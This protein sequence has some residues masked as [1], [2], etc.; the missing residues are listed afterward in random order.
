[1][2][3]YTFEKQGGFD[4][5]RM[6]A[7][8]GK[9]INRH[10]ILRT[11]AI[12]TP[13]FSNNI[14]HIVLRDSGDQVDWTFKSYPD[15]ASRDLAVEVY[16]RNAPGFVL[17]R[18]PTRAALFQGPESSV[19]AWQI[20][21][22]QYDGWSFP[23][24]LKDLQSAYES[25]NGTNTTEHSSPPL[26]AAF[27]RWVNQQD[28]VSSLEYWKSHLM[29]AS[30]L[31]WP[32]VSYKHASSIV[33]DELQTHTWSRG[34]DVARFCGAQRITLS[35]LV[36][37]A[38]AVVLGKQEGTED[39]LFGVVTS[40]RT[41]DLKG[42]EDIVGSCI[43]TV[44]C[45]IR[46]P[47]HTAIEQLLKSVHQQSMDS[48][49]FQFVGLSDIIQ[50]HQGGSDSRGLFNILLVIENLPGLK[51][52]DH[53]FVGRNLRGH[54]LEMNY[55]LT[56]IVFP[57]PDN[58]ELQFQIQWDS[59]CLSS[60][61]IQWFCSHLFTAL[62][63]I[64]ENPEQEVCQVRMLSS[65]EERFVR[66][67]GAGH[68]PD[69]LLSSYKFFHTLVDD[70]AAQ[71]PSS[72]ALECFSGAALSYGELVT[73]ANQAAHGLQLRGVRPEVLVP[74]IF[75]KFQSAV[76]TV[77]SL[78]A[79]MKSAGAFVPLDAS[80]PAE[81]IASCIRQTRSKFVLCH[82]QIPIIKKALGIPVVTLEDL[83][84]GHDIHTPVT[85]GLRESSLSYVMFTSG[86]T[87][88]PKGVMLEHSNMMAFISKYV[89][90]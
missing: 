69:P 30:P 80:W 58:S 60:T 23:L 51:D 3:H 46:I 31:S 66:T 37:T 81:R 42:I 33:T 1:M 70:I 40:G 41:G 4:P 65:A 68:P 5:L 47:S 2:A 63:V 54:Q 7:A 22:S 75:D 13:G 89:L 36:R 38:L 62:D 9:V 26:Y 32:K 57:S 82:S 84:R 64:M 44:P 59:R 78:L 15:Q 55:P 45:R 76:D 10:A 34:Q 16:L 8:W 39:V 79:I 43:A 14:S 24:I 27:V 20:H 17:G 19:L 74:I 28:A 88:T 35:S 90:R 61:D 49:P 6:E 25:N 29:E 83:S 50:A 71:R 56:I 12:V 72:V 11:T 86:S 85:R 73:R 18:I 48:T 52:A 21:H 53:S 87:G 77:V 67:V